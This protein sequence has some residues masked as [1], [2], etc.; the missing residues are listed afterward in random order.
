MTP[1]TPTDDELV[2]GLG[3]TMPTLEQ[4]VAAFAEAEADLASESG[5]LSGIPEPTPPTTDATVRPCSPLPWRAGS[6]PKWEIFAADG[7]PIHPSWLPADVAYIIHAANR[8][9]AVLEALAVSRRELAAAVQRADEFHE[10]ILAMGGYHA[11]SEREIEI[12]AALKDTPEKERD[13]ADHAIA[14]LLLLVDV[15]RNRL[16]EAV[17]RAEVAERLVESWEEASGIQ[18][19]A[20]KMQMAVVLSYLVRLQPDDELPSGSPLE[21]ADQMTSA[22][23][24]RL[25]KA[26][27]QVKELT[28]ALETLVDEDCPACAGEAC[29]NC[30]A[31]RVLSKWSVK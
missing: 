8:F 3:R 9:P 28:A 4:I 2:L 29:P 12:A 20:A 23:R 10:R 6:P 16:D 14:E 18:D 31:A 13:P 19:R 21:V 7:T 15:G 17:Q 30:R 22:A 27:Q 25:A 24:D 26:E 1:S 5:D 11:R